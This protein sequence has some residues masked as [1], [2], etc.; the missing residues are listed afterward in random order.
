MNTKVLVTYATKHGS[1]EQMAN[2]IATGLNA[3]QVDVMDVQ[4]VQSLRDYDFVI[5]GTP[6]YNNEPLPEMKSFITNHHSELDAVEKAVYIVTTQ[7]DSQSTRDLYSAKMANYLPGPIKHMELFSGEI[8]LTEL[9]DLEKQETRGYFNKI[10]VP[11]Q[12]YNF[13][14]SNDFISFSQKINDQLNN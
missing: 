14:G 3:N 12:S 13:V 10:D 2:F 5:L 1:T 7:D 6:M 4:N 9:S 8:D 11:M